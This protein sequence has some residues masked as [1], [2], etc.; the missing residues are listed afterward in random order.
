MVG[1]LGCFYSRVQY[2]LEL[3]LPVVANRASLNLVCVF[4][5]D[6]LLC[7]YSL[8]CSSGH[9]VRAI[10]RLT[11]LFSSITDHIPV[12]TIVQYLKAIVSHILSNFLIVYCFFFLVVY[13]LLLFNV[14]DK[15]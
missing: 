3:S 12:L 9:K 6:C 2:F 11:L 7:F 1:V 10:V 4:Q 13:C 5:L 8:K 14:R 15:S